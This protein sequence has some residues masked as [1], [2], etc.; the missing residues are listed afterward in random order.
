[1]R[2]RHNNNS[3]S[4]SC[5]NISIDQLS[6]QHHHHHVIFNLSKNTCRTLPS[7]KHIKRLLQQQQLQSVIDQKQNQKQSRIVETTKVTDGIAADSPTSS[8]NNRF[9]KQLTLAIRSLS[10]SDD[11]CDN[12]TAT[13]N[14]KCEEG[15]E[16]SVAHQNAQL[17]LESKSS[18]SGKPGILKVSCNPHKS[19]EWQNVCCN[20][21]LNMRPTEIEARLLEH[22]STS[23]DD[24][25]DE[26]GGNSDLFHDCSSVTSSD[27]N[28]P[29]LV[30]G[31]CDYS[32]SSE[33]ENDLEEL[34]DGEFHTPPSHYRPVDSMISP[35]ATTTTTTTT[36]V[37]NRKNNQSR[38]R[39]SRGKRRRH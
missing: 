15:E 23:G 4:N 1:M 11:D 6:K 13:S 31:G 9:G 30:R 8:N 24:D 39:K 37:R 36:F 21:T 7:K 17:H 32:S 38:K 18:R 16:E 22:L 33:H 10:I 35:T 5:N 2:Q 27:S 26:L 34:D 19:Q 20:R 12:D 28:F 14:S 25:E 3:N 29:N